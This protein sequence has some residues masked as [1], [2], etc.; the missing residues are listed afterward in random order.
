MP[1]EALPSDAE[2]LRKIIADCE[3]TDH[4]IR[5][6]LVDIRALKRVARQA[7][8]PRYQSAEARAHLCREV[9]RL[10]ASLDRPGVVSPTIRSYLAV[11]SAERFGAPTEFFRL[12]LQ[13][14]TEL[15]AAASRRLVELQAVATPGTGPAASPKPENPQNPTRRAR[16]TRPL[17]LIQKAI[18][19][20][21][22]RAKKPSESIRVQELV[23][24]SA[25]WHAFLRA[26]W[27]PARNQVGLPDSGRL[28]AR[29]YMASV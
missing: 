19:I 13:R 1:T 5:T 27:H 21:Q 18:V 7:G 10:R 2:S 23:K 8:D 15:H 22:Y 17:S 3:A 12:M 16:R 14:V 9:E 6:R 4:D 20:L 29:I 25:L 28:R 24:L 26:I 11:P